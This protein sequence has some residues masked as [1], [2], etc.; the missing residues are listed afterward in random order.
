[1]RVARRRATMAKHS[2][3]AAPDAPADAAPPSPA[4][5]YFA[6]PPQLSM[7][8]YNAQPPPYQYSTPT[9]YGFSPAYYPPQP[10][11][12]V[13]WQSQPFSY[14][15]PPPP[16]LWSQDAD[17]KRSHQ[18]PPMPPP[19]HHQH[20]LQQ[21]MPP[22]HFAYPPRGHPTQHSY[23]YAAAGGRD[24]K[25][26]DVAASPNQAAATGNSRGAGSPHSKRSAGRRRSAGAAN[27][28]SGAPS[29][30]NSASSTP[31]KGRPPARASSAKSDLEE[32]EEASR[33]LSANARQAVDSA[34]EVT[35]ALLLTSW[36]SQLE[37]TQTQSASAAPNFDAVFR[38]SHAL[39]IVSESI[40]FMQI[41]ADSAVQ[42]ALISLYG[43]VLYGDEA[44]HRKLADAAR[45]L[46]DALCTADISTTPEQPSMDLLVSSLQKNLN[47]NSASFSS[48]FTY[49]QAAVYKVL[50]VLRDIADDVAAYNGILPTSPAD[51]SR[52]SGKLGTGNL[53]PAGPDPTKV[54][55]R[56]MDAWR[57]ACARLQGEM[58]IVVVLEEAL[59]G[60][61]VHLTPPTGSSPELAHFFARVG[62]IVKARLKLDIEQRN[63][64]LRETWWT[65]VATTDATSVFEAVDARS[66]VWLGL[67]QNGL[68]DLESQLNNIGLGFGPA[69][70]VSAAKVPSLVGCSAGVAALVS[71]H[72]H[73]LDWCGETA[74][75]LCSM[76]VAFR[77]LSETHG[78]LYSPPKHLVQLFRQGVNRAALS[79]VG[80]QEWSFN[81]VYEKIVGSL[82]KSTSNLGASA[83]RVK[84]IRFEEPEKNDSTR[85]LSMEGH[86]DGKGGADNDSGQQRRRKP[87]HARMKSSP[88]ELLHLNAHLEAPNGAAPNGEEVESCG[89]CSDTSPRRSGDLERQSP[90]S[91]MT[92]TSESLKSVEN[93]NVDL[94]SKQAKKGELPVLY[95]EKLLEYSGEDDEE[96]RHIVVHEDVDVDG[97]NSTSEPKKVSHHARSMSVDGIPFGV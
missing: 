5:Q 8:M 78:G 52:N 12:Y 90:S 40:L 65:H 6:P 37:D 25:H 91:R 54:V 88:D 95:E 94:C 66:C 93:T 41:S 77:A 97:G 22:Q 7:P 27:S 62:T 44:M 9:P 80:V 15:A 85:N 13:P 83:P 18:H 21:Q 60:I 49:K 46:R 31:S 82:H 84:G 57:R 67:F 33:A 3:S 92:S 38:A 23:A 2:A 53:S 73:A 72:S 16:A 89:E 75:L 30:P 48:N 96:D 32:I 28:N 51:K 42:K 4:S 58:A 11:L 36:A 17:A 59:V 69:A 71:T 39:E 43:F 45:K 1:M 86:E 81:A 79:I 76:S 47:I 20:A 34:D 87:R 63:K 64:T 29:T 55:E 56:S 70:R 35:L 24:P 10:P 74:K 19:M 14:Y 50:G 61:D 68:S 26:P